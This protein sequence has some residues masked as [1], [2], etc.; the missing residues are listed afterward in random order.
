M[1]RP[2]WGCGSFASHIRTVT[3]MGTTVRLVAPTAPTEPGVSDLMG[4]PSFGGHISGNNSG[5]AAS[6]EPQLE[7]IWQWSP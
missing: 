1:R 2:Q 6:R 4:L 7:G 5:A 3:V